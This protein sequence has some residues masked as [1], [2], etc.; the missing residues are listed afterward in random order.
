[1]KVV[2][3]ACYGGFGLS[4]EAIDRLKELAEQENDKEL[5]ER[6]NKDRIQS[7]KI[8]K[9]FGIDTRKYYGLNDISRTHSLLIKVVEELGEKASDE[10]SCLEIVEVP[11]DVDWYIDVYDGFEWVA[12]KHRTW[13]PKN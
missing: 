10:Y 3:N 2:I 7:E 4:D 1:M 12:E 8:K 11:D 9:E 5:L 13:Y 6:I